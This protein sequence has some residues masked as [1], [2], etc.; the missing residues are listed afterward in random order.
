MGAAGFRTQALMNAKITP[1][2]VVAEAWENP[3]VVEFE[4]TTQVSSVISPKGKGL[5]ELG[6]ES[7]RKF[8]R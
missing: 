5:A 6:E 4:T 2:N 8:V 3:T 1:Y 7:L